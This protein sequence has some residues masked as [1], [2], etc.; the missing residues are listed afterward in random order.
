MSIVTSV[1]LS[2]ISTSLLP[3][4]WTSLRFDRVGTGV[5]VGVGIVKA[6]IGFGFGANLEK[7]LK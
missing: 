5:W 4:S 3:F 1:K 7:D 6:L 2:S